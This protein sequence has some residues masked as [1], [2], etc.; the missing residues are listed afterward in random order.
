MEG[1]AGSTGTFQVWLLWYGWDP[2]S[3]FIPL[4]AHWWRIIRRRL[5]LSSDFSAPSVQTAICPSVRIY[6]AEKRRRRDMG[7]AQFLFVPL[8]WFDFQFHSPTK[9][10]I[11][12]NW[13]S[14]PLLKTGT[15]FA[16]KFWRDASRRRN[17]CNVAGQRTWVR[18]CKQIT[19]HVN[20]F[21]NEFSFCP[22]Y[23]FFL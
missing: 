21:T 20:V 6:A 14:I 13:I 3:C 18:L 2:N 12:N 11:R 16:L 5:A 22:I 17:C 1:R 19:E 10:P 4:P 15:V 8:H 23:I 7:R 9:F